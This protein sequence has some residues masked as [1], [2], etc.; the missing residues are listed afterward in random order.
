MRAFK[1]RRRNLRGNLDRPFLAVGHR[2]QFTPTIASSFFESRF[3]HRAVDR[4]IIIM[5]AKRMLRIFNWPGWDPRDIETF[6]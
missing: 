4:E 5:Y 6:R 2:F 1:Q 3:R